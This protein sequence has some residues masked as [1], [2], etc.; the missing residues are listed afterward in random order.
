MKAID[1]LLG[2][3]VQQ[4]GTELRLLSN[5]RPQ[6]FNEEGEL[7]LTVPAMSSEQIREL[8]DDLWTAHEAELRQHRRL[9]I[10]YRSP[11]LGSFAVRLA[12]SDL[13]DL[14]IRF[15][16]D[17][18]EIQPRD[19]SPSGAAGGHSG[20][21]SAAGGEEPGPLPAPLVALLAR[22]AAREPATST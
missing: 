20:L 7:P 6:M 2:I 14:D 15:R 8:L 1:S 17:G 18:T 22:A 11:E 3:P 5:H 16:R 21:A 13:A 4:G 12:Q 19:E 9:S 10:S